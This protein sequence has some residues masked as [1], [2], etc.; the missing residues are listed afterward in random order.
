MLILM[1]GAAK[2]DEIMT[3][4]ELTSVISPS[5]T[6]QQLI[7]DSNP[8]GGGQLQRLAL[9]RDF[10]FPSF[11]CMD[12]PTSALDEITAEAIITSLK[13]LHI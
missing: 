11:V 2:I 6:L 5:F 8:L 1:V 4:F 3:K 9:A 13:T 7:S 10:M 12:E